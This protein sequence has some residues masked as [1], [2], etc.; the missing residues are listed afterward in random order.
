GGPG[1]SVMQRW[2]MISLVLALAV[3]V[4]VSRYKQQRGGPRPGDTVTPTITSGTHWFAGQPAMLAVRLL[5]RGEEETPRSLD[6][7]RGVS[8]TPRA[9]VPFFRDEQPYG[10]PLEVQL[11]HRCC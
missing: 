6:F 5:A 1:V 3:V 7:I 11:S 2:V 10:P 8:A 9:T 4:G